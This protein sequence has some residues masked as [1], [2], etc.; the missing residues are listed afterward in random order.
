M[1]KIAI[2]IDFSEKTHNTINYGVELAKIYGADIELI[3]V[4]SIL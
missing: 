3:Y 2:P 4:R 1:R